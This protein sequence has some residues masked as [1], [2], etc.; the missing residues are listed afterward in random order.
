MLIF[1]CRS[2]QEPLKLLYT[3]INGLET[4]SN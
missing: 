2:L 1:K 4:N 3:A